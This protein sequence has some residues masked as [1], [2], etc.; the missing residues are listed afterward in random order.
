MLKLEGKLQREM[1]LII[2]SVHIRANRQKYESDQTSRPS[3]TENADQRIKAYSR[4]LKSDIRGAQTGENKRF[5]NLMM[6]AMMMSNQTSMLQKP[7][8]MVQEEETAKMASEYTPLKIL[9]N[10]NIPVNDSAIPD[11]PQS[12]ILNNL[13][14]RVSNQSPNN[15]SK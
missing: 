4:K 15:M 6:M 1:Y 10:L 11:M 7:K 14:S 13:Q 3:L 9:Q 5:M 12:S 8:M 2:I